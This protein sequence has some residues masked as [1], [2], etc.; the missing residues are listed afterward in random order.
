MRRN[1]VKIIGSL[2]LLLAIPTKVMAA[3]APIVTPVPIS[4]QLESTTNNKP[5]GM[6][7]YSFE[8]SVAEAKLLTTELASGPTNAN[9]QFENLFAR[10]NLYALLETNP[11]ELEQINKGIPG[12]YPLTF[13][14]S[15]NG[16]LLE[17]TVQVTVMADKDNTIIYFAGGA[18]IGLSVIF[19]IV[20]MR[21]KRK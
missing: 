1:L 14:V 12:V 4:G 15:F 16:D 10:I 8:I 13:K 7:A 18:V 5:L 6:S 19:I 3:T 11:M 20:I 2:L 21:A 9:I 17:N